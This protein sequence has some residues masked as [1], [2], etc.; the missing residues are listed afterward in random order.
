MRNAAEGMW[1]YFTMS[2]DI[3]TYI[4]ITV[5]EK[6]LAVAPVLFYLYV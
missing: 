5:F 1:R 4:Y 3:G 6:K 2:T